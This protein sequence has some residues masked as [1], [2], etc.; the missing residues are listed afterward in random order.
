MEFSMFLHSMHPIHHP[1]LS[2]QHPFSLSTVS[3]GFPSPAE[4]YLEN[5]DLKEWLIQ[6]P[7]ST[8]LIRVQGH[9]MQDMGIFSDDVL[10]VDRA[11]TAHHGSV[12]IAI[13]HGEFLV[14][15]LIHRQNDVILRAANPNYPDI[16]INDGDPF[17]VWGVVCY[18]IH[19]L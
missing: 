4:E 12:I 10:I 13:F 1:P 8:F 15:Q 18:C 2:T 6:R 9:S 7:N 3:A 14:K 17:E 16:I 11:P 5:I 19:P